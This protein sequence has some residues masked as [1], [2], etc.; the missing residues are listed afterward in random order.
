MIEID[1]N[2]GIFNF[3]NNWTESELEVPEPTITLIPPKLYPLG[4]D[5]NLENVKTLPKIQY[6]FKNE[7]LNEQRRKSVKDGFLHA[8]NGYK[9][10]AWGKDEILPVSNS[11][12][13][14]FNGWAASM[15]ESLDTMWLMGIKDEF[16]IA[17][18]YI[19]NKIDFSVCDSEISLFETVIRYLGSLLSAYELSNDKMFL[20]KAIQLGD[21]LIPAFKSPHGLPYNAWNIERGLKDPNYRPQSSYVVLAQVAT[22]Q[23]EFMKLS[24]LSGNST[25]FFKAQ[26][27]VDLLDK[28]VKKIPGLYPTMISLDTGTF[29]RS[30]MSFGG[31]G[32]SFYE[33]LIK[34]YILVG[35]SRDQYKRMY[36]ESI[37]GMHEHLIKKGQI[38]DKND[39]LFIGELNAFDT[40]TNKMGHLSC[41]VPGMLAIGSKILNRPK[42]LEVAKGLIESCY[43]AYNTSLSGI[44]PE[45]FMF[46]YKTGDDNQSSYDYLSSIDKTIESL[47]VMYRVTGDKKYQDMGWNIWMAIEK[48]CKTDSAYSGLLNVNAEKPIKNDNMESFFLAETLKYLYLLFSPSDLISLDDYVF[49]TEAHPF[50]IIKP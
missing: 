24:Q 28:A 35:G 1:N 2:T 40:F 30:S 7:T 48:K 23:L 13:D 27:V 36:E 3:S 5:F 21:S 17:R 15:V 44:G 43:L 25:Y 32:D 37:N 49:N 9:K 39:L 29:Y 26:A 10:H 11:S 38:K 14:N 50:R 18:D 12:R 34:D 20:R 6:N 41:F 8:W 4:S 19:D 22:L 47:F 31:S 45:E 33:Y 46:P 16:K 42:D